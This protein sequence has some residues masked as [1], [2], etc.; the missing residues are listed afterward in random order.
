LSLGCGVD[1]ELYEPFFD[2]L[3]EMSEDAGFRIRGI[4]AP[5][6]VGQG[7]SGVRNEDK[8]G[9][10]GIFC[11]YLETNVVDW[12]DNSRDLLKM[13]S[14][15]DIPQPVIGMGHSMGGAQMYPSP[16]TFLHPILLDGVDI[17][18]MLRYVNLLY[19][20]RL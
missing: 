13:F 6:F 19:S 9:D 10:T 14:L 16:S 4:W 17:G 18:F 7:A 20:L 8:L 2:A 15:F 12:L 1:K 11:Y 3:L 5:D